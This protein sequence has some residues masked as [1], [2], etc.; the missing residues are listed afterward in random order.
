MVLATTLGLSGGLLAGD[1]C[2]GDG[3]S[4]AGC[5]HYANH[6]EYWGDCRQS[7]GNTCYFCQYTCDDGSYDSCGEDADEPAPYFQMCQQRYDEL[8]QNRH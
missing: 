7:Q 6:T 3:Y 4:E 5:T 8:L 2:L 1:E